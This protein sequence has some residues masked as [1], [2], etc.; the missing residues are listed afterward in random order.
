MAPKTK[1]FCRMAE[2]VDFSQGFIGCCAFRQR[3]RVGEH[4]VFG[5]AL[6]H[7]APTFISKDCSQLMY[8][9]PLKGDAP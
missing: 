7:A 1:N 2:K 8:L 9:K 5:V 4:S 6:A 3:S